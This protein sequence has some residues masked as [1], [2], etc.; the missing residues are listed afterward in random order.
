MR[1]FRKL[2]AVSLAAAVLIA[3]PGPAC[4]QAAAQTIGM[5]G[6]AGS[7]SVSPVGIV[8]VLNAPAGV[9]S[10]SAPGMPT[11]SLSA[12]L[13][14]APVPSAVTAN[15]AVVP[16]VALAPSPVSALPQASLAL[17]RTLAP[18][19][20]AE[21]PGRLDALYSGGVPRG[22][23]DAVV[24]QANPV[25][26]S[27]V[28]LTRGARSVSALLREYRAGGKAATGRK[29]RFTGVGGRDV[30]NPTAP[31]RAMFRGK[32]VSVMA[33][34]VE[35]RDSESSEAVF[36]EKSR[37]RWRPLAGAPRFK[38]QDPFVSFI[39]GELVMGGVETFPQDGGLGYRT[40]F[41]R[42]ASL[43]ELKRFAVG[44]DGMKDIRL[45]ELP[46]G[47]LL[48]LTRPQGEIG[49]PGKIA[50]VVLDGLAALKP[51]AIERAKPYDDLFTA[52][53]W[54]GANE[55][56]LLRNGLIGVLG[57]VARF[58][59]KGKRH[60]Y[61]MAFAIDPATGRRTRMKLLLERS[62]LPAGASKRP[63]L[64]DVLFSGGLIRGR[65]GRAAIYVGAGDA[66]VY[67]VEIADPFAELDG[68]AA[69]F[70]KNDELF[71]DDLQH[72][73]FLYFLEQTDP[74][75]GLTK[76]R[77]GN[78]GGGDRGIASMAATG[79]GLTALT[80]GAE[81]GWITRE[82]AYARVLTTLRHLREHQAHEHG[83][84][85]HFVDGA[86]GEPVTG[87]EVSSIDTAL[88]LAG[89]LT[90]GKHFAGTEAE[91]L[92]QEIYERVD[93]P[94]MMTDGGA[95]PESRTLAMGWTPKGFIPARWDAYS[96]HQIL[97]MLGLGSPTHPLPVEAWRAWKRPEK[98]PVTEASSPLFTHQFSQLWLDL[99]GWDDAG[100]DYFANSVEATLTHRDAAIAAKRKHAAYGSNC[101][102]WTSCDGPQGYRA[103]GANPNGLEHD[104]TIAPAA[105]G[106]SMAFTP[107]LS[108]AALRHMKKKY[109]DR[110]WGRYGFADAFNADPA[111]KERFN[112]P[113]LW[114]SPDAV[115]IDQGAILLAVENARTGGVW[116][117][118][119]ST[120]HARR[121][122]ERLGR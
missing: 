78:F 86:T 5:A 14:P 36:F 106:G 24:A 45:A 90:A 57:H 89:A 105:A 63:D 48:V 104:G 103:Y 3:A 20:A 51:D 18:A 54:G 17:S 28:V 96:E 114:R 94:W 81:R 95:K 111:Q 40:V 2:A 110:I 73:A 75:T 30:Y 25:R 34:R 74:V 101:W 79:F 22:A 99:R 35:S 91:R 82:E 41:Y 9:P 7:V 80:I 1:L 67:R 59:A 121:A 122:F 112:A 44:P 71:L 55:L 10:L 12:A 37:G 6:R 29:L 84:F 115:G 98:G 62:R 15:L 107:E 31:F 60:Y 85:H 120:G 64:E 58:D 47:K 117:K 70:S 88:L 118:F 49:G 4:H 43:G 11:L 109:G 38:L 56:H 50:T 52:E 13:V 87:S 27:E 39:G 113:G 72:K 8:P 65:D 83:W 21:M 33:A 69:V 53:Q 16:I 68:G 61:P 93:F 23:A 76:D 42:G 116:R 32:A 100:Q 26:K 92:T 66:E 97:Y 108:L 46:G 77:A 102:G 19:P 119:M